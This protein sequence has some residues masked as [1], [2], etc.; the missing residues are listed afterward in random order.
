[1]A[2]ETPT[3]PAQGPGTP[4]AAPSPAPGPAAAQQVARKT[5]KAFTGIKKLGIWPQLGELLRD[6]FS[7]DRRT[8]RV[9][10]YFV[11]S[12]LGVAGVLIAGGVHL[13]E[14]RDQMEMQLTN[15]G[16]QGRNLGDFIAKQAEEA[17]RKFSIQSLGTFTIEIKAPDGQT[18]RPPGVMNLADLEMAV[19]CDSKPTCDFVEDRMSQIRNLVTDVFVPMDREE[20]LSREGKHRLKKQIMDKINDWLPRGKIQ[21]LYIDKL[22]IS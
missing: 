2:T 12:V 17:K 21:D 9:A 18:R 6:L 8:R 7:P 10:R 4:A 22:I 16:D 14:L 13:K 15:T 3:T 20:L 1:M 11:L 19:Q 5:K